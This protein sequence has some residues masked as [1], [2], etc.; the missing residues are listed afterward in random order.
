M[1]AGILKLGRSDSQRFSSFIH[2]CT[3]RKKGYFQCWI[4]PSFHRL[5]D[6]SFLMASSLFFFFFFSLCTH[7]AAR[8][9]TR[10]GDGIQILTAFFLFS[11]LLLICPFCSP[12]VSVTPKNPCGE[13]LLLF[14]S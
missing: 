1:A 10:G 8:L 13:F 2:Q 6:A 7:G 3:S 5:M 4:I 14:R 11:S 9:C 12:T